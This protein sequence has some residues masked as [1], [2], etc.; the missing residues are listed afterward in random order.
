MKGRYWSREDAVRWGRDLKPGTNTPIQGKRYMN[1]KTVC[2]NVYQVH[3]ADKKPIR[4]F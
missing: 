1:V 2:G 4:G 3:S